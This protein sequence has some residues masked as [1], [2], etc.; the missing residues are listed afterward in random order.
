LG[1]AG[2]GGGIYWALVRMIRNYKEGLKIAK[3]DWQLTVA[4]DA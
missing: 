4:P 1:C 3:S 2:G